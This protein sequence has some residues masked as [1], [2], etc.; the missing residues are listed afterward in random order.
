MLWPE[1]LGKNNKMYLYM[2]VHVHDVSISPY[3]PKARGIFQMLRMFH[4][5]AKM[6]EPSSNLRG[7]GLH[8]T[9]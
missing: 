8:C 7:Y 2:Y 5:R 6:Q 3:K 1:H 4:K 9:E